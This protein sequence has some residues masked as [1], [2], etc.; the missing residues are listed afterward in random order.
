MH[1]T[2]TGG[3]SLF[4]SMPPPSALTRASLSSSRTTRARLRVLVRLAAGSSSSPLGTPF[5]SPGRHGT[6]TLALVAAVLFALPVGCRPS[7]ASSSCDSTLLG[8]RPSTRDAAST[9]MLQRAGCRSEGLADRLG[10]T[11]L[12]E[13]TAANVADGEVEERELEAA[14]HREQLRAHTHT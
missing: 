6:G 12:R 8:L 2:C 13:G 14:E 7:T 10:P 5:P 4:N 9:P 1:D 11:H 3:A